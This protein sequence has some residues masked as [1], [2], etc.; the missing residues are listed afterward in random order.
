MGR[1]HSVETAPSAAQSAIV[2]P[3][4][5]MAGHV[6]ADDLAVGV[7]DGGLVDDPA[8]GEADHTLSGRSEFHIV[9]HKYDTETLLI[10]FFEQLE[11]RLRSFCIQISSWFVC[12][13]QFRFVV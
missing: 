9:R 7:L 4:S 5:S 10:Q 3:S 13:E 12:Q 8:V 6:V 1:I 2:N 11:N